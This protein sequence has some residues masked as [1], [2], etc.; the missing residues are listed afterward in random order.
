[1]QK[2]RLFL[3][4]LSGGIVGGMAMQF[5]AFGNEL[6]HPTNVLEEEDFWR[7][8]RKS[9]PLQ[10]S[11]VYFNTGTFGP[12][13]TQV[14]Q[15]VRKKSE[16]IA[17]TGDYGDT[18]QVREVFARFLK[19]GKE[20]IS[21]THNTTEGI[22]IAA[23]ALPLKEGDEVI[24]TMQE[25]V[26]NALPWLNVARQKGIVLRPFEPAVTSAAVITQ[27][28]GLITKN[29]RAIAIP[30]ITCTTGQVLPIKEICKIAQ[31]QQISTVIDGA[32][33]AGTMDL[34]LTALGC[35]FYAGCCHKW[36]LGPAG[37]GFL[38]VKK[39]VVEK[40]AP[41]FVGAHSDTGWTLEPNNYS[42]KGFAPSAHRFDYGTQ[43]S[44]LFA[45]AAEAVSLFETLGMVRIN[46]RIKAL[47][48][49]LYKGLLSLSDQVEM[50]TP[51]EQQSRISMVTFR[52]KR[53]DY[54]VVNAL[55]LKQGFRLRAVP[56]SNLNA[57]RISTHIYNSYQEIDR[58]VGFCREAL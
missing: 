48:S 1:M 11:K 5:P 56:E 33:G 54:L 22:N 7:E 4:K 17:E 55:A 12:S 6:N 21:L 24:I 47:A 39:S 20:E 9:F 26:G 13:S 2:R 58:F 51:E 16:S 10:E 43:N 8:L 40:Y 41:L 45:G 28:Q 18:E 52:P 42:I 46:T 57:L 35:D 25:H 36:L 29:T 15:K 14:L 3:K 19:A 38:F 49:Y 23:W 37:T 53:K 44:A 32:H 34:D 27:V 31:A 30:H 50:L